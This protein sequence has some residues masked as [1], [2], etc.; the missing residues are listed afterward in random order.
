MLAPPT[1]QA[2]AYTT[3]VNTALTLP[4]TTGVLTNDTPND[5]TQPTVPPRANLK[6]LSELVRC[7]AQPKHAADQTVQPFVGE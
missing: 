1:F 2:D 3:N 5:A 6:K 7:S 4:A